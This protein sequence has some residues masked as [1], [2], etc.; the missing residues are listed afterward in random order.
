MNFWSFFYKLPLCI[1]N[2][3]KQSTQSERPTCAVEKQPALQR[4]S[5]GLLPI[6]QKVAPFLHK[7]TSFHAPAILIM[8]RHHLYIY[9]KELW[10]P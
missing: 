7:E 4:S 3:T 8:T 5:L 10:R 6:S 2:E 9:F 1:I